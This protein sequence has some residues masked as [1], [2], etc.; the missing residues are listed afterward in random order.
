MPY[1]DSHHV[2][3]TSAQWDERAIEFWVVP[4]GCLCVELTPEGKT[5]IKIGEG[6]KFYSQ[7]P[8]VNDISDLEN[9]YT[10]EEV[11]NIV[12]N[13]NLMAI[14]STDEYDTK[15]DLPSIGNKL[16]DVRFVKSP[17]P[18]IKTD[19]DIYLWNGS[20]W[21]YVGYELQD[22]DLSQYLKKD[23]FHELFDPVREKVEEMYPKMH[24]HENK[25]ILDR[26][27]E[28]YS[29]A[30]KEKLAGLE[31]YDD[32]EIRELIAETGHTH[33]NKP[34]LD[35]ITDDSL[36]SESDRTK[37]E[38]L[39]N[40]DDTG[41]RNRLTDLE[42]TAHTHSNK[43]ILDQVT[44]AFTVED[45]TKL[46]SLH[47]NE[48]F[49]GTDGMYGGREGLVP[50]PTIMDAGKF[51]CADGTWKAAGEVVYDFRGATASEDGTNGLVPAP[52]A[53]EQ[54]YYL[55][56]DG[57]WAKIKQGGDKYKA[58]EGIFILSGEVVSD[59]F[60]FKAYSKSGHLSQYIIYGNTGG[61]GEN[62]GGGAYG[63]NISITDEHGNIS[64]TSIIL[65]EKI[66]FG[67]YID[68]EKQVFV[69]MRTNVSSLINT[70][71]SNYSYRWAIRSNGNISPTDIGA[72]GSSPQV[73]T[74]AELEPGTTYEL[75][76]ACT[77]PAF[78]NYM[79]LNVYDTEQNRTRT[80]NF[81]DSTGNVPTIIA[82][83]P[84]EKYIRLTYE[85]GSFYPY[86]LIKVKAVETPTTLPQ[87]PLFPNSINTIN[88]TNTIK[89]A[90]I[91]IEVAE[92]SEDDPDDPMSDFT[93]II[94]NDGVLDI[95]QGDPNALNELTVHFRE[96]DKVI[97]IPAGHTYTAGDGIDIDANDEISAK[98]GSG[99]QFDANG[100][101][102][103]TG[104][105]G[106]EYV[107]GD[108]IRI[109]S[110]QVRSTSSTFKVFANGTAQAIDYTIDGAVG[111]VG[112]PSVNIYVPIDSTA[113]NKNSW[114][115]D[116]TYN[117]QPVYKSSIQWTGLCEQFWVEPGYWTFSIYAKRSVNDPGNGCRLYVIPDSYYSHYDQR[118]VVDYP[119]S[120]GGS[121]EE[122][123]PTTEWQRFSMTI[124]VT[125]A[126]YVGPRFEKE[127]R[128]SD[129][130]YVSCFQFESGSEATVFEEYG[131]HSIPIAI[132]AP[133]ETGMNTSINLTAAVGNGE[134][135]N[136]TDDSLPALPLYQN[137]VNT[138]TIGTAVAPSGVY[139]DAQAPGSTAYSKIIEN[140]G[141]LNVTQNQQALNE[142]TFETV[143][144]D[145]TI[146]IPSDS[147]TLPAAT[148]STLGGIIVGENL[149]IDENGV[150]DAIG[151]KTYVEGDAIEFGHPGMTD[152]GFDFDTFV[153]KFTPP[154]NG[155]VSV[156]S[157]NKAFTLTAT[158]SD[159]YTNPWVSGSLYTIPVIGGRKYRL[160]WNSNAS[161]VDGTIYAFENA[162]TS[163]M[164]AVNQADQNYL[165]FTAD[166]SSNVNF[167]FGVTNSG[168]SITFSNIK[169]YEIDNA[170]PDTNIINVKYGNG[171]SLDNSNR[172]QA[173]TMTGADGTN[174][175][176]AGIVPAPVATDN[177]KFLKGDGTWSDTPTYTLPIASSNTLG[178]IKVGN[179]L[180]IDPVTGVLNATGGGTTYA[181]GQGI[182]IETDTVA[183]YEDLHFDYYA[184]K[185]KIQGVLNGSISF[186]IPNHALT[187]SATNNY[188]YVFPYSD[189]DGQ[190]YKIPVEPNEDYLLTWE[191]N[192]TTIAGKV[193]VFEN[194]DVTVGH[195]NPAGRESAASQQFL[196][197]TSSTAE[198]IHIRPYVYDGGTS[199]TFSNFQL[200]HVI[201][202]TSGKIINAKIGSGLTFDSNNAIEA[203]P[204]T[205]PAASASTLGGVKVGD[206][207]DID[208][209]GVLEVDT[210]TGLTIDGN[211][212]VSLTPATTTTLGGVIV[213]AGLQVAADGKLSVKYPYVTSVTNTQGVPGSINVAKYDGTST[214]VDILES[215]RLI[216]N[217]NF[218]SSQNQTQLGE[219]VNA[220]SSGDTI[221][222]A[223]MGDLTVLEVNE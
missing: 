117:G 108:G 21:I 52:L 123:Y 4:R 24:T 188:C 152:L 36:W 112:D 191:V 146:T 92:P 66:S 79:N 76:H 51:L 102:E 20:R 33:P 63:I 171:L 61:V 185:D 105:G 87:I 83:G 88:V 116:G 96:S 145:I 211:D 205:L 203:I 140:T 221:G 212:A 16:G 103:A 122:F 80:I 222:S 192:D 93:G 68:Y 119:N 217:C 177:T 110:D 178:G 28:P 46:D 44:A 59:T 128:G 23:E 57:T 53:G 219:P 27:E 220:P 182:E 47:N 157:A 174:A 158:G 65:P 167:R 89:P 159:C 136:Y 142:L 74:L 200:Y 138:I 161:N 141:L 149:T 78:S 17:S 115:K 155:I 56:G 129:M 124:H 54:S 95:T 15:N 214:D 86:T 197:T 194:G 169:F 64:N 202:D 131:K 216:L 213:D 106:S 72:Y 166:T 45:K 147:Y 143:D 208:A 40:Y 10:K 209:N 144:G 183:T 13:I 99:L 49:I 120:W 170:D 195:Y 132:T 187:I 90:E 9:Y 206:G 32:T 69:H 165:E 58:G 97:T 172:L 11:D 210:G 37:F 41:V 34:V 150:L 50:A 133:G 189:S 18:S 85:H 168:N 104:G 35:T 7:L 162:S 39:H 94:Y 181:A 73:T 3:K 70:V 100:A 176:T 164:H 31:N 223:I 156:D 109:I 48:V 151:G 14:R 67:D 196:F 130:L 114:T 180:T 137:K 135:I 134:S 111:G 91:Y 22:I 42:S 38:S 19:P 186:D 6:N 215:L 55:K 43:N 139:V 207:L 98:L 126:G 193:D 75:Y 107:Q 163:H 12:K 179:N 26:I 25:N 125:T 175:G 148:T 5:K 2:V 30:E 121:Y 184:F 77:Y 71:D 84:N 190:L 8:Y 204:Y 1:N 201:Y 154:N 60:P 62:M 82:L 127:Y 173:N 218:D 81:Y 113:V 160:T 101:I 153:S 198:T 29:T 118:A 199:L